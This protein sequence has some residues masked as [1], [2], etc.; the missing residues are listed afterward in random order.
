MELDK[1]TISNLNKIHLLLAIGSNLRNSNPQESI[2]YTRQ[3]I[4]LA[5]KEGNVVKQAKGFELI[6]GAYYFQSKFDSAYFASKESLNLYQS[7]KDEEGEANVYN[8]FGLIEEGKG[9]FEIS[10]KYY[11]KALVTY[12]KVGDK[13]GIANV[14]NNLAFIY[15]AEG[16]TDKEVEVLEECLKITIAQNDTLGLPSTLNNLG[17]AYRR[18]GLYFKSLL[19]HEKAAEIAIRKSDKY[20]EAAAYNY[21]GL[22]YKGLGEYETAVNYYLKSIEIKKKIN[23]PRG[24]YNSYLNIGNIFLE[25]NQYDKAIEYQFKAYG[26]FK[27]LEMLEKTNL[28]LLNIAAIYNNLKQPKKMITYATEGLKIAVENNFIDQEINAKITLGSAY[29]LQNRDDKALL[30]YNEVL[31]LKPQ[32][33]YLSTI[34]VNL[35]RIYND[36]NEYNTARIYAD[37]AT[38]YAK[39]LEHQIEVIELISKILFNQNAFKDAYLFQEKYFILKDSLETNS[40]LSEITIIEG[41]YDFKF[42]RDSVNLEL[43]KVNE[44]RELQS[45][46]IQLQYILIASILLI[47]GLIGYLFYSSNRKNN[48]LN[49][50]QKALKSLN[51]QLEIQNF[52]LENARKQSDNLR[53]E[54][55][56]RVKN[57]MMSVEALLKMQAHQAINPNV[58]AALITG[59]NRIK[60]MSTLHNILTYREETATTNINMKD[61][62][63]KL[64]SSIKESHDDKIQIE[65]KVEAVLLDIKYAGSLG[66]IINELVE[67]SYKHAFRNINIDTPQIIVQFKKVN[68][69]FELMIKD[70]G[71]GFGKSDN[72]DSQSLGLELVE[73]LIEDLPNARVN[74]VSNDGTAYII[75]F[76]K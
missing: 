34:Y 28:A 11:S 27:E 62:L 23:N 53:S 73:L 67:N 64:I 32:T 45:N 15:R 63:D 56:H 61:Y 7:I 18:K 49:Q 76:T 33:N 71:S 26:G 46:Q 25:L 55:Q 22:I 58:K 9:N 40:Q 66:F 43:Q 4:K 35:S 30:I 44:V 13:N 10:N 36:K 60:A 16:K 70:N 38:L 42:K 39:Q 74:R 59:Q 31:N 37:S 47:L 54:L 68:E 50:N 12:K 41:K 29:R 19:N 48:L 14:L 3:G 51:S 72:T 2:S 8:L 57:N 69:A 17:G 52:E 20:N 65:N 5:Q 1:S 21:I 6:G 24:V 75:Q